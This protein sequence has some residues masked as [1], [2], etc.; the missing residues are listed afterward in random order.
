MANAMDYKK[1]YK[2]LYLPKT[3]PTVI[4]VPEM[5]FVAV[6]GKGDP[7][8]KNGEYQ[9]ALGI[10]YGIQFTIKMSKMGNNKLAGYF[11]YIVPPL[12]GF[13]WAEDNEQIF[14]KDKSKYNWISIIRLPEFVNKEIFNWACDEVTKKKNIETKIAK[15]IKIKEGL[16]VQCMHIGSYDNEPKTIKMIDDFIKEN[17]LKNDINEKRRHHEI[18]LSDP[19]KTETSKLK[20]VIRIPVK[21]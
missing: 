13:W 20:T 19:R 15:Y 11:D 9:R 2:D 10:L 6:E 8:D 1:E 21:K 18:Y 4:N 14:M 7:N 17:N 12:E 16:C 3:K 5:S